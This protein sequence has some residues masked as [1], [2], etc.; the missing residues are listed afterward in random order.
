VAKTG[1]PT[2]KRLK[3][4]TET[5][6]EDLFGRPHFSPEEQVLYFSLSPSEELALRDLRTFESRA[7]F[8]LQLGYFKA[9]HQF[10]MFS[11]REVQHDAQYVQ[12]RYFRDRVFPDEYEVSKPTRLDQQQLILKLCQYQSCD[13]AMKQQLAEKALHSARIS[14]KPI[15][16]L[17]ELLQYLEDRRWIPPGYTFFQDCIG[18]ALQAEAQRLV[19][20]VQ[21]ELTEA[22]GQALARL[23]A[24]SD[25]LYAITRIKRDP[26]DFSE[27]ELKRE[28]E[29]GQ[30]MKALYQTAQRALPHLDISNESIKQYASL[31]EYYSVF[32]MKKLDEDLLPVYLLCFVFHRYRKFHD[33]LIQTL[34]YHV[35][36]YRDEAKQA[37]KER[38]YQYRLETNQNL[39][40]AGRVLK[41]FTRDELD[42]DSPFQTVQAQ[43][44]TILERTPLD[45]VADY[46]AHQA[47]FD[48]KA[49]AWEYIDSS[50][51]RLKRR[52]RPLL[53]SVEWAA[54]SDHH[55]VLEAVRFLVDLFKQDKALNHELDLPTRF[56]PKA[57]RRYVYQV[58]PDGQKQ[59]RLDRY[60]FLLYRRLRHSLEAGNLFC[61]DSVSFRSLEGRSGRR[62]ALA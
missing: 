2:K 35:K 10:Y 56:I 52:L 7:Y 16:I 30:D 53:Q 25:T 31:V 11:I 51:R 32:R 50:K 61:R 12:E 19:G 13:E 44:F 46:I 8:I 21:S 17:R 57:L 60:E 37:A 33:H 38:V 5:E 18:Q 54:W 4:L 20:L 27:K 28:I 24:D 47:Q 34:M 41:L 1:D 26:R 36:Q 45:R 29:R 43:A 62:R 22:D 58:G 15:Y 39:P 59:L 55:P 6:I 49:F 3:I 9:Q 40:K 23:T 42:P 48:E 14:N